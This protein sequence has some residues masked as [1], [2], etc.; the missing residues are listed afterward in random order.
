MLKECGEKYNLPKPLPLYVSTVTDTPM[1]CGLFRCSVVLPDQEFTPEQLRY[2]FLHELAHCRRDNLLKWI[3]VLA[4]SVNWF[5]P[6]VYLASRETGRLCKLSCDETVT[7][8]FSREERINYGRM[9]LSVASD[10]VHKPIMLSAMMSED[11]RSLKERL[12]MLVKAKKRGKRTVIL[13]VSAIT[14]AAV[15]T[16]FSLMVSG[17]KKA[18]ISDSDSSSTDSSSVCTETNMNLNTASVDI[19]SADS[20][21]AGSDTNTVPLSNM[22]IPITNTI[23]DVLKTKY[24]DINITSE[25]NAGYPVIFGSLKN[26]PRQGV[27]VIIDNL[28]NTDHRYYTPS[29]RGAVTVQKLSGYNSTVQVAAADGHIWLFCHCYGF[30]ETGEYAG[31]WEEVDASSQ[32]VEGTIVSLNK[33]TDGTAVLNLN[34][35]MNIHCNGDRTDDQNYPYHIGSTQ[36]FVLQKLP[37]INL[38]AGE[39][40]VIYAV[41]TD[42]LLSTERFDAAA[43]EYYK[44]GDKYL[45]MNGKTVA[46][47]PQDYPKFDQVFDSVYNKFP[48]TT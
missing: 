38:D 25:W 31:P 47:P 32:Y 37:G 15:I 6:A 22:W 35:I 21:G 33:S 9:L 4:V 26:D 20:S 14:A 36:E 18:A 48:P 34:I 19:S 40:I 28:N 24:S 5:N 7:K 44:K 3:A 17:V 29:K 46:M 39:D 13:T 27:A 2:A 11:K 8:G 16:A 43:V 23:S 41:G 30:Y 45:N 42:T 1:L 10:S 12:E